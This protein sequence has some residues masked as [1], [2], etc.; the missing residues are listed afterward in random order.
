MQTLQFSK[1]IDSIVKDL[2]SEE[3]IEF[4]RPFF[5][6]GGTNNITDEQRDQFSSIIMSSRVG[7][8][9]LIKEPI[10]NAV[11]DSLR[12]G[13]LYAPERLGRLIRHLGAIPNVAQLV[14]NPIFYS[15]FYTLFDGLSWL[16]KLR[17]TS[18]QLLEDDKLAGVPSNEILQV[19]ILDYDN[20]GIE[21]E[22]LGTFFASISEIHSQLSILLKVSESHLR[23]I[24]A[25]SGSD[26]VV[27][28]QCTKA[29]LDILR[30]LLSEFWEKIKYSSF[31]DFDKKIDSMSKGLT[32]IGAVNE[33]IE[34]GAISEEDGKNLSHRVLREMKTLASIG[35]S[36][37]QDEFVVTVDQRK[38]MMEVRELKL[39]GDGSDSDNGKS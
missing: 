11:M 31:E 30:G 34:S 19:R 3:L 24:Y 2:R 22:R 9:E 18:K 33:Q 8:A 23:V 16:V 10:A 21:T 12:I 13:D 20:T 6:F 17:N 32:F 28:L 27:G 39:I 25:D 1:A 7:Y 14:S 38:L 26:F 37:P 4:I 15:E 5:L 36:L 29:I 35:V